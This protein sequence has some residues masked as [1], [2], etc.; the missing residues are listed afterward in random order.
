[1]FYGKVIGSKVEQIVGAPGEG[2]GRKHPRL[3]VNGR[4]EVLLAWTEGTGWQRG[5]SLAW[6]VFDARGKATEKGSALGVEVWSFG[7]AAARTDGGFAV[8][9]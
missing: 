1:V 9:Y 3:A 6:Q 5:G 2:K 7:A 8:I 4:G